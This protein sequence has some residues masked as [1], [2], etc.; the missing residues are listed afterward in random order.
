MDVRILDRE[1]N[2]LPPGE[3]GLIHISGGPRF[4][5]HGD[6]AK[7]AASWRGD[8]FIP[9]DIGYLDPDDWLFICDRR[10]DL[11]LSGGVNVYPAEVEGELLQHPA[12]ADAVV[13]GVPDP[14][15]GHRVVALVA[16][17]DGAAATEEEL[18]AHCRCRLAGFKCPRQVVFRAALPRNQA[19][20][21]NR[22]RVREAF[23][24]S[25]GEP[26]A[27]P[28]AEPRIPL[29]A[30]PAADRRTAACTGKARQ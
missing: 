5:Y 27:P 13:I 7:T 15:W 14:E 25:L 10:T 9:G 17:Q 30:E 4:G 24:A 29:P 22:S 23:L 8:Y 26:T 6:P 2:D 20:K 3:P 19:G 12:V 21:I 28:T 11:I 18:A 16:L 1:G